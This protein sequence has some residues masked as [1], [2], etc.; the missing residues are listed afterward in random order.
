MRPL[1][2]VSRA[3]VCLIADAADVAAHRRPRVTIASRDRSVSIDRRG[4]VPRFTIDCQRDRLI[5]VELLGTILERGRDKDGRGENERGG[6]RKKRRK[7]R[8]VWEEG[9]RDGRRASG[10]GGRSEGAEYERDGTIVLEKEGGRE[11]R[12]VESARVRQSERK[13][14]TFIEG[15]GGERWNDSEHERGKERDT[16]RT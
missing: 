11:T 13:R 15:G 10:G 12:G 9:E 1:Y 14:N 4:R 8:R 7:R 16:A 2:R 6:R 3:V 5:P